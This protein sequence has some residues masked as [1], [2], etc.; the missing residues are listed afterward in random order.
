M[1]IESVLQPVPNFLAG[2]EPED[3]AIAGQAQLRIGNGR[4]GLSGGA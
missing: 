2:S 3:P 4:A 1:A